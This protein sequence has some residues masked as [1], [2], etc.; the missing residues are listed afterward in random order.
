M[1]A[2][3]GVLG[4]FAL[5]RLGFGPLAR[6]T[7]LRLQDAHRRAG[8]EEEGEVDETGDALMRP[9]PRW[10]EE[11][12]VCQ[13]R[14]QP[15]GQEAGPQTAIPAADDIGADKGQKYPRA[16]FEGWVQEPTDE[17]GHRGTQECE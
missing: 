11:G 1:R 15:G 13:T 3:Q 4:M 9:A 5:G 16:C 17:E 6:A 12:I 14:P 8:D 7:E 10:R 2:A